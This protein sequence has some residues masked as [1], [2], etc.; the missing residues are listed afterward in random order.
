[1]LNLLDL[2][3]PSKCVF[4]EN[5]GALVC[6]SCLASFRRV[7]KFY[8]YPLNGKEDHEKR[9]FSDFA[10]PK[11]LRVFSYFS[12]E[13]QIRECIKYSKYSKKQ[14]A[15]LREI[16]KYAVAHM[17]LERIHFFSPDSKE[18]NS[19]PNVIPIPLS[20]A[21]QKYRGFNQAEVIASVFA[22]G[23]GLGAQNSILTRQ[24]DTEAQHRLNKD[25][26][27]KN[28]SGAFAVP[29][30]VAAQSFILVDDICT[31]GATLI[32]AANTFYASGA[33][34]VTAFTLSKRL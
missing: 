18:F 11:E 33:K 27:L 34:E 26:R 23:Y 22:K 32:E 9:A 16:T 30:R 1:M 2:V 10:P 20:K 5:Y 31:T 21:K 19:R 3:F 13:N 29:P 24:K 15:I 7:S 14:F 12:Y 17:L 8:I 4:C 25:E 6:D 28:I